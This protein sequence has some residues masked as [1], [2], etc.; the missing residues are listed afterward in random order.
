MLIFGLVHSSTWICLKLCLFMSY[1]P[2]YLIH[3]C[4]DTVSVRKTTVVDL[5][6]VFYSGDRQGQGQTLGVL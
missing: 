4:D 1:E 5:Y 6:V 2:L 3:S